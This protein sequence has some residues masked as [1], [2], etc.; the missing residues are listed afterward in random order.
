MRVLS[1]AFNASLHTPFLHEEVPFTRVVKRGWWVSPHTLS[2]ERGLFYTLHKTHL[3][4]SLHTL[5]LHEKILCIKLLFVRVSYSFAAS[6][7]VVLHFTSV[8][9]SVCIHRALFESRGLF[10]VILVVK[11]SY[12]FAASYQIALHSSS[13]SGSFRIHTALFAF[14]RLFSHSYGSFCIHS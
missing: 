3:S 12:S 13:S 8:W 7:Q 1:N 11:V 2:T 14:I 10:I 9:S 4:A 5:F 6:F